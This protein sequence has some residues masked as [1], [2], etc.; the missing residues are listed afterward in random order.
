MYGISRDGGMADA[1]WVDPSC[2]RP[3]P[4]T[5]TLED[6]CLV[7]PLAVAVH[8]VD[9][10]GVEGGM[11]VL[12]IGAGP[13]GLAA[14]A[15]LTARGIAPD[16]AAHRP[17]RMEAAERLGGTLSVGRDYDVVLEAAGTQDSMNGAATLARPGGTIGILSSFWSPVAIDLGV[18]MKEI[19]IIPSFTY[20]HHEGES[21]FDMAADLLG[22][23]PD[24]AMTM[25]THRFDLGDAA[26]A[27]RVASDRT[28]PA[29]KVV[30]MP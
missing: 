21:E 6:A 12:V 28:A 30:L 7:E 24:I 25:V 17:N 18:L 13:I 19:T 29:I 4:E 20:G 11:R 8:G 5:L 2:A 15:A 9:R 10:A 26:E 1:A 14:I 27:F 23:Q 22:R 16:V 3:L